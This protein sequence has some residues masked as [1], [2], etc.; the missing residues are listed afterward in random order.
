[1]FVYVK[2]FCLH[3]LC[4]HLRNLTQHRVAPTTGKNKNI[5]GV[6]ACVLAFQICMEDTTILCTASTGHC[7]LYPHSWFGRDDWLQSRQRDG[8]DGYLEC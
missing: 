6:A 5:A 1:M 8:K 4:K 7:E 3:F 2:P